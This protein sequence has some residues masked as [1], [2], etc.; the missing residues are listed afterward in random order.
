MNNE[1]DMSKTD[2]EDKL[3]RVLHATEHPEEYTDEQL[4]ELLRDE[5]CAA[6]Y[7]LMCDASTA[8]VFMTARCF[9]A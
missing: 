6:Y 4:E 1:E 9:T 2:N 8:P 5:E 7:R 3:T